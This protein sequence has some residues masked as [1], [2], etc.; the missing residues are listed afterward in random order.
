MPQITA[1]S[2]RPFDRSILTICFFLSISVIYKMS[3]YSWWH[4]DIFGGICLDFCHQLV[5]IIMRYLPFC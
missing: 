3:L 5:A 1:H 4:F 2:R